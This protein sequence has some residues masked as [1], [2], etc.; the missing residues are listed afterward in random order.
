MTVEELEE[1]L[2]EETHQRISHS[3][4]SRKVLPYVQRHEFEGLLFSDVSAFT[5]LPDAP[6]N[7]KASLSEIRSQ[8]RT[9]EDINHNQNTAPSKRILKLMPR[10]RKIA[11]ASVVAERWDS[12]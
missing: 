8:F 11:G 4:D 1:N 12:M 5:T 3:W 7:L 2:T 9:P 6:T 10:Y